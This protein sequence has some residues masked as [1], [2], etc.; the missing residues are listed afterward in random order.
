MNLKNAPIYYALAQI[1]FN[2]VLKMSKYIEDIQD[3][4]RVNGFPVFDTANTV[5]FVVSAGTD[6]QPKVEANNIPEWVF[7]DDDQ[8]SGFILMKDSL[9]FHTTHYQSKEQLIHVLV[10]GIKIVDK[11]LQLGRIK[12]LGLRFLDAVVP[13]AGQT[14]SDYLVESVRGLDLGLRR[15]Q[16]INESV[17]QTTPG[18]AGV[19]GVLLAKVYHRNGAIGYPPD[20]FVRN[21]VNHPNVTEQGEGAHAIL[22]TDHYVE[23]DIQLSA[24]NIEQQI[25]HLHAGLKLAFE[26][27]VTSQALT[28]WKG[29]GDL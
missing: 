14:T 10:T 2:P 3:E 21:L 16:S 23:G 8:L 5:G 11:S 26:K 22:D 13:R 27:L 24:E 19:S 12:R 17:F 29:D 1:R 6:D 9:T 18:P 20:V 28:T 25:L 7:S 4:F 15:I